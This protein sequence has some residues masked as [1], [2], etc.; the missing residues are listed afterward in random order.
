MSENARAL[1][2]VVPLNN[3][4]SNIETLKLDDGI[5][6][7]SIS[8]DER[9]KLRDSFPG[10]HEMLTT[11]LTDVNYVLVL[12]MK[13]LVPI[14]GEIAFRLDRQPGVHNTILALRLL[15][16]G[17]VVTSCGFLLNRSWE[18]S[19]LTGLSFPEFSPN[20]YI[21]EQ[22]EARTFRRLW[23]TLQNVKEDK[24]HMDFPLFQFTRSFDKKNSEDKIVDYMT[25]FESLIFYNEPR[26]IEPAGK[27]I[28]IAIGMLLGTNQEARDKI[29][30]TFINAYLVRNAKVHGNIG[31]LKKLRESQDVSKLSTFVEDYLRRA[32]RKFIEE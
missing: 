29:K 14:E 12:E 15:K 2:W 11:A 31:N 6:L 28:G 25:C 27:V 32:L 10:Y 22:K 16:S 23:K 3:F 5:Y 19:A 21:L 13:T 8:N 1:L 7:R 20:P 18:V 17:D 24:P 4:S 9:N 30:D 26:T